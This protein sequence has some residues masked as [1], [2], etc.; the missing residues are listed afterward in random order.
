MDIPYNPPLVAN[1]RT[2]ELAQVHYHATLLPFRC[3]PA[4]VDTAFVPLSLLRKMLSHRQRNMHWK[5][6]QSKKEPELV[7]TKSQGGCLEQCYNNVAVSFGDVRPCAV[8]VL[9][10]SGARVSR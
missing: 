2:I 8:D 4:N 1:V 5:C 6:R 9:L 10:D 3:K 7:L